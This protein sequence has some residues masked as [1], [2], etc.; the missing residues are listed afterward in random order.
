MAAS[1]ADADHAEEWQRI[2]ASEPPPLPLDF[3]GGELPIDFGGG[4]ADAETTETERLREALGLAT[5]RLTSLEE[6]MR[7]ITERL[8][9]AGQRE[10]PYQG[11]ATLPDSWQQQLASGS[12]RTFAPPPSSPRLVVWK[13]L[14]DLA[15]SSPCSVIPPP[16]TPS[17]ELPAVLPLSVN[18]SQA[19]ART[20]LKNSFRRRRCRVNPGVER[21]PTQACCMEHD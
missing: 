20:A 13:A 4:E 17:L 12:E 8:W 10:N 6:E 16:P 11:K 3:G 14:G 1:L 21:T 15:A 5:I 2:F 19:K 7:R 18:E 9:H